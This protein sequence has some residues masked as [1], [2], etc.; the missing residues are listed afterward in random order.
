MVGVIGNSITLSSKVNNCLLSAP[1][2][3]DLTTTFNEAL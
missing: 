1:R 3:Y 2:N